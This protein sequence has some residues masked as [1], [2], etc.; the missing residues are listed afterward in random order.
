MISNSFLLHQLQETIKW[1]D[2]HGTCGDKPSSLGKYLMEVELA[3]LDD[4]FGCV[5]NGKRRIKDYF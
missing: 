2:Q 5:N 1:L 3:G 4:G